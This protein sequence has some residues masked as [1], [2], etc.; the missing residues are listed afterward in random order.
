MDRKYP[1]WLFCTYF[2]LVLMCCGGG[3]QQLKTWGDACSNSSECGGGLICVGVCK[4]V[5]EATKEGYGASCRDDSW[6][7]G[8]LKCISG[9]CS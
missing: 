3:A 5:T 9:T 6:C 4:D 7:P 2:S 8:D 1:E